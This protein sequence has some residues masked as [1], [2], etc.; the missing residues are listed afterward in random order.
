MGFNK[1]KM[2]PLVAKLGEYLKEAFDHCVEMEAKGI[3]IDPDTVS[4]FMSDQMKGWNPK[5]NGK[6]LLDPD[7]RKAACRFVAGVAFNLSK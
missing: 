7:T 2:L 6:E 1:M 5:L 3:K 4:I